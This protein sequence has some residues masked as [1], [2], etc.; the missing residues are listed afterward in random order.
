M[1]SSCNVFPI[2]LLELDIVQIRP[3][4]LDMYLATVRKKIFSEIKDIPVENPIFYDLEDEEIIV[5]DS[6][7]SGCASRKSAM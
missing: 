4:H 3:V 2:L 1:S 6:I 5:T 7:G